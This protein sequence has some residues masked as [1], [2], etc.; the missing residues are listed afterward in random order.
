MLVSRDIPG[1]T[2]LCF[3]FFTTVPNNGPKNGPKLNKRQ[4]ILTF[5]RSYIRIDVTEIVL[6]T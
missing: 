1:A 6:N 4:K 2:F 3:A 5:C